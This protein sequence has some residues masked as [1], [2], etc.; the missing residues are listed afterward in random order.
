MAEKQISL[1]LERIASF[2]PS[3]TFFA[4]IGSDHAYLP[5][6]VC[7]QDEKARA[8]AGEF[9]EGPFLSAK[10]NVK[11]A[12]LA[13]RVQV[14]K[15]NGLSVL[16][17]NDS[18]SEVVIAGMGGSLI[19]RILEEGKEKLTGVVKII[20]Q[21]NVDARSVRLWMDLHRYQIVQEDIVKEGGHIYEIIVA[22][23]NE[24]V[25]VGQLDEKDLLIGP[26]LKHHRSEIFREKWQVEKEK[27]EMALKQM[28]KAT[29][30]DK[31]KVEGFEREIAIIEE[32]LNNE[33]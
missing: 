18:I 17:A 31:E 14:R 28:T 33:G 32:V 3:A 19:A 10:Q 9:N 24:D 15:G 29:D 27:R 11:E 25:S 13:S 6:Y 26:F 7:R 2:L 22:D 20:A 30:I 12:N 1:R 5:L 21:P 16:Q 8:I 4:D 23:F